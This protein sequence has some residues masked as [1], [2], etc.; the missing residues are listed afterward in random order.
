MSLDF[1]LTADKIRI[2]LCKELQ[3]ISGPLPFI[4]VYLKDYLEYLENA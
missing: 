3:D 1:H 4:V 2:S